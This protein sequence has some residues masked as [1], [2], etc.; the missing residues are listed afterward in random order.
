MCCFSLNAD[1][2]LCT[3][4]AYNLASF[5]SLLQDR[6]TGSG[7]ASVMKISCTLNAGDRMPQCDHYTAVLFILCCV[8]QYDQLMVMGYF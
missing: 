5:A 6:E 7:M 2:A 8:Y 3:V 1:G 4:Q